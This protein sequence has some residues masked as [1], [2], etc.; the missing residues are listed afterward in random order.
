MLILI[1]YEVL[2]HFVFDVWENGNDLIESLL[3]N[4]SNIAV[5]LRLDSGSSPLVRDQGDF[6]KV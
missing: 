4:K 5:E 6:T 2:F 3:V 1:L